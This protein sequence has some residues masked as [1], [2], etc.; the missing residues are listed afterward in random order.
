MKVRNM[1]SDRSGREVANQFIIEDDNGN[2]Y[3]QSYDSIICKVD[4]KGKVILDRRFWDYSRTTAKYRN[5]FLN[6]DTAE[7]KQLINK[8]VYEL[9]DLN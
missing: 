1:V 9:G 2:E 6:R 4:K 3:F 8:N 7:I 5:M